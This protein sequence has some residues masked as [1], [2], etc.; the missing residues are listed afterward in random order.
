MIGWS[1]VA[2]VQVLQ[3]PQFPTNLSHQHQN[4]SISDRA[5]KKKKKIGWDLKLAGTL[6]ESAVCSTLG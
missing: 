6:V 5:T 3:I 4:C 1:T 2:L